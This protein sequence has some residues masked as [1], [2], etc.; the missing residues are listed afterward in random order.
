MHHEGEPK[1]A[2]DGKVREPVAA[3]VA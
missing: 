3:S 1:S 2:S